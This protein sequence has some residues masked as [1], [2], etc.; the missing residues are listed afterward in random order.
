MAG[1]SPTRTPA[2]CR[3]SPTGSR[4][5]WSGCACLC[6]SG[7]AGGRG[8]G[9]V[10]SGRPH[11]DRRWADPPSGESRGLAEDLTRRTALALDNARLYERQKATSHALQ[12]SLLP[13]EL[14]VIPGVE[15][16]AEYEAAG[17]ANEVGGDFYDIFPVD[18]V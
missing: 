16:A 5:R 17:E 18:P 15:L 6:S 10:V 8:L 13:P 14:P 7:S 12:H 11:G 1:C 3:G 2:A 4:C 9:L